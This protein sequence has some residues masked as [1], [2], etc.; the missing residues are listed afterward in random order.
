MFRQDLYPTASLLAQI[1]LFRDDLCLTGE[2]KT[3][4]EIAK[5][6]QRTKAGVN[7]ILIRLDKKDT[8]ILDCLID[9]IVYWKNGKQVVDTT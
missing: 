8:K 7:R 6:L 9:G 5:E 4:E 1:T 2:G 3:F